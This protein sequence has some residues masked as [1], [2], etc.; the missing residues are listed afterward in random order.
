MEVLWN[1]IKKLQ[2]FWLFYFTI[3]PLF[4]SQY[5]NCFILQYFH[6]FISQYLF[7]SIRHQTAAYVLF[8]ERVL[9]I[10]T[11]GSRGCNLCT[12]VDTP[13]EAAWCFLF[14]VSQHVYVCLC[15]WACMYVYVCVSERVC[16]FLFKLLRTCVRAI[17]HKCLCSNF[18]LWLS[19]QCSP[20]I[21]NMFFLI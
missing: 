12:T 20:P 16:M 18:S 6:C 4:I 8:G 17:V 13:A 9:F 3:L 11:I 15:E 21:E 1:K 5:F 10:G 19:V 14:N 2:R 7:Y